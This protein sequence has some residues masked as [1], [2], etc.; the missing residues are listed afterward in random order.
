MQERGSRPVRVLVV[1][2]S[3]FIRRAVERM[4]SGV[5][6]L[7]VVGAAT[8]GLE[9]VEMVRELRPDVALLDVNMPEMDGLE[10]LRR[11]MREVPTPV[12]LIS[13][14]AK[15]G[16]EVTLRALELGAVDFIDK[17]SVG[18]AMDIY[19]LAPILREKVLA[20]ASADPLTRSAPPE[21][22]DEAGPTA[23]TAPQLARPCR[24]DIVAIGA[25]TGGPRALSEILP[26]LP[27]DLGAGVVVA[28]HMPAGFTETLAERLNRRCALHVSEA[29]DGDRVEPG[30]ILIAPGRRQ[31]TAERQA[32]GL[33][34]R[35]SRDTE[36]SLHQPSADLLFASV[37]RA[38]GS[39]AVGII[40]TG[41]GED[42]AQGL[43]LLQE[44]GAHTLVESQ[45]T[46]VIYGMPRAARPFAEQV[47]PLE[48]IAPAVVE[49]CASEEKREY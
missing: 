1:D 4:L 14:L 44:A 6:E 45:E 22:S 21:V 27:G 3:A 16:A 5:P 35:V 33:V 20:V 18:T 2:D 47:L 42:G 43:Q 24:F 23:P 15:P 25:S 46:A 40:L 28:Q 39:R 29:R 36:Q 19:D 10:A 37:A 7:E 17:G 26:Q 8:N 9:A 48:R 49:I 41:M 13:T 31:T 30:R 12:L 38:S 11:I 34:V 32:G